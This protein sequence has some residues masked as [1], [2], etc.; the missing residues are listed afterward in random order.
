[1]YRSRYRIYRPESLGPMG[2]RGQDVDLTRHTTLSNTALLD[3]G[4]NFISVGP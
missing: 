3:D 4:R 1:M 2:A